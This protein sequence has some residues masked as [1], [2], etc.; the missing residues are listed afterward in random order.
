MPARTVQRRAHLHCGALQGTSNTWISRQSQ[1]GPR[2]LETSARL[3]AAPAR[4]QIP[5]V[6]RITSWMLRH[7]DSLTVHEQIGLKQVLAS[8]RHLEATAGHVT[9]FAE[10][11]TESPGAQ[12]NSWTSAVSA[13]TFHTCVNFVRGLE[14][15]HAAVLNGLT[16]PYSSGAVEGHANRIKMLKRRC[17]D[18]PD[19]TCS[20]NEYSSATDAFK[21]QSRKVCQNQVSTVVHNQ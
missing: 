1:N 11:P 7:P 20:A 18:A 10:M 9:S 13:M 14:T 2:L 15:D 3:D 12:F 5:K 16:L 6:R 4:R 19:S 17:T 21:N 8:C